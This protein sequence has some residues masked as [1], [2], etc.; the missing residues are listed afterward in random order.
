ML[1]IKD[2][3]LTGEPRYRVR[4]NNGNI[5]QDNVSIEQITP[6]LQE[7]TPVNKALVEGLQ[8]EM[9]SDTKL[10]VAEYTSTEELK[11]IKIEGL[12]IDADGGVYDV[13]L[14]VYGDA[15]NFS[16]KCNE[17]SYEITDI[18]TNQNTSRI[19]INL[20]IS[21]TNEVVGISGLAGR[22]SEYTVQGKT[23]ETNENITSI[24]FY[25]NNTNANYK[26]GVGCNIKIYKRR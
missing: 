2:E 22:A 11:E 26:I 9:L 7:G 10:L 12:D 23:F 4:D 25:I 6:A 21:K 16:V 19:N 15:M 3:I 5:I 1:E 18:I 13:L 24:T 17:G 20:T 14:S 8:Q